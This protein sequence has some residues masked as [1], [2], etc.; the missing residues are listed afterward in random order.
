MVKKR[1]SVVVSIFLVLVGGMTGCAVQ[2]VDWSMTESE[3]AGTW[4]MEQ[5]DGDVILDLDVDGT[6]VAQ[7]WPIGLCSPQVT[8]LSEL[9]WRV[10]TDFGGTYSFL[11]DEPYLGFLEPTDSGC[12]G[13]S[14]YFWKGPGGARWIQFDLVPEDGSEP[15]EFVRLDRVE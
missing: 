11:N 3:A 13:V 1:T 2:D 5:P 8:S 7:E 4:K 10:R 9:D 12:G 6:F 15:T 14:F